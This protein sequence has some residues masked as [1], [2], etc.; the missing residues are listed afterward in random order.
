MGRDLALDKDDVLLRFQVEGQKQRVHV[1]DLLAEFLRVLADRDGVKVRDA[2]G[3]FELIG[4]VAPVLESAKVIAEGRDAA[5][6]D[7]TQDAFLF[8]FHSKHSF[9]F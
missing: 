4:D 8:G 9:H 6:L 1:A 3:T 2:E 5:R 7:E